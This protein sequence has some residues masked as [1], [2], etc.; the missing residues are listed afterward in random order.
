MKEAL[1]PNGVVLVN[2]LSN[3]ALHHVGVVKIDF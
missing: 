3:P 2:L 1:L